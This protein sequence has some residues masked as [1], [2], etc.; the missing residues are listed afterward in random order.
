LALWQKKM[1][2]EGNKEAAAFGR[3]I[4]KLQARKRPLS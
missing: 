3:A 4:M 1:K 2:G